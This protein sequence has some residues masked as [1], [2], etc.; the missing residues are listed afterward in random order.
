MPQNQMVPQNANVKS[1]SSAEKIDLQF[2]KAEE[3]KLIRNLKRNDSERLMLMF[4]LMKTGRM[5]ESGKI[6]EKNQDG[7]IK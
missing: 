5:M 4:Q 2:E 3:Q 7:S 1:N 6:V